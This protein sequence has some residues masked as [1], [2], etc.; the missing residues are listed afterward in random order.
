MRTF[1]GWLDDMNYE[2]G[3]STKFYASIDDL[4]LDDNNSGDIIEFKVNSAGVPVRVKRYPVHTIEEY[5]L[6]EWC[7][8]ETE[9]SEDNCIAFSRSDEN[10]ERMLTLVDL[11]KN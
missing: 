2:G 8:W 10:Y 5:E 4:I 11:T 7:K 1:Y 3:V 9:M 6:F